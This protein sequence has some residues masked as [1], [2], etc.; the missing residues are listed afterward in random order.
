[1]PSPAIAPIYVAGLTQKFLRRG[2]AKSEGATACALHRHQAVAVEDENP[3]LRPQPS[4]LIL[5]FLQTHSCTCKCLAINFRVLR[6]S[7]AQEISKLRRPSQIFMLR[8]AGRPSDAAASGINSPASQ[9]NS[10]CRLEPQQPG[11]SGSANSM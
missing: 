1:M 2:G 11:M 10:I 3:Q 8:P 5:K 4:L 9:P 6:I 7:Y